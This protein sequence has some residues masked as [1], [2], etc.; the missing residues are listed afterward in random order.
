MTD[1]LEIHGDIYG[2]AYVDRV[3]L[4]NDFRG[5]RLHLA[6]RRTYAVVQAALDAA[7]VADA[8]VDLMHAANRGAE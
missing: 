5:D 8:W 6:V 3:A 7:H 1:L 4:Y 2:H